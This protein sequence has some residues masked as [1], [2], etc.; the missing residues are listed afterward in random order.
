VTTL[1]LTLPEALLRANAALR[2]GRI[3]EAESLCRAMLRAN[4]DSVE[5][6]HLLAQVEARRGATHEALATIDMALAR[7]PTLVAGHHLRASLLRK[8]GLRPQ[9]L[10]AYGKALE[11]KPRYPEAFHDRASLL[12][13]MNRLGEALAD[14]DRGL[15]VK[16]DYAELHY[17]RAIVLRTMNRW[18]DAVAAFAKTIA[19]KP[20]HAP[21]RF[22]K[23]IAEL[24]ILY[25]SEAEIAERRAGY[26]QALRLLC[27]AF[28]LGLPGLAEGIGSFQPFFLAYQGRND[29]A[30]QALYGA[31]ISRLA[32]EKYGEATIAPPPA[33]GESIR[34]GIVSGYFR[35]HSNW[36]QPISGWLGQLDRKRFEIFGYHTGALV[37]EATKTAAAQCRRFVQGPLSIERWREEISRDTPHVLIYPE[38]GMD[39]TVPALAAQRLAAVQCGFWGHP[40]TSGFPTVDYFLSSELMEPLDGDAHY[41]EKLVRLPNLSIYYEPVEL[42]PVAVRRAK[43]GLRDGATLFWC[44]QSVFK[45]LPQHDDVFPRIVRQAGDCQ[46]VF[47]QAADRPHVTALFWMRLAQVFARHGLKIDD[48]AVL[49]PRLSMAEFTAVSGLCDV[50]LDSI[51]W[52]GGNTT[53]ESL[54]NDLPIVTLPGPTMRSR[55]SAAI[56]QRMGIADTVARDVDN[57]VELAVRMAREPAWRQSMKAKVSAAKH[58]V[59]RDRSAIEGLE[60]FLER[61]A[62]QA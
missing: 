4:A 60:R 17:L 44:S 12:K 24:P 14:C 2:N 51:G 18:R 5:A 32:A 15:A 59:Y 8:L 22:G 11:L 13:D 16:P 36:K 48:H 50:F 52:S 20:E 27:D 7:Q 29:R 39:P 37:D 30:A 31:L 6:L 28:A 54:V 53:L 61:A 25:M 42:V 40:E 35:M 1:S 9:A 38:I 57:Y 41:T 45:Y 3:E 43:F 10:A 21:A 26:E 49:L 55:H 34:V 56:L 23:V 58:R 33:S 46:F 19:L 62:R 47:V